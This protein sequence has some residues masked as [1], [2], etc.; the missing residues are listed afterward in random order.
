VN[1]SQLRT[2]TEEWLKVSVPYLA[3][4]A[5]AIYDVK[6][7]KDVIL[8]EALKLSGTLQVNLTYQ[9]TLQDKDQLRLR[10]HYA[11]S[12]ACPHQRVVACIVAVVCAFLHKNSYQGAAVCLCNERG[13]GTY[14]WPGKEVDDIHFWKCLTFPEGTEVAAA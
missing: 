9:P 11:I 14:F 3:A 13:E 7:E 10:T 5:P 1:D 4:V 8:R 12:R 6:P 2:V